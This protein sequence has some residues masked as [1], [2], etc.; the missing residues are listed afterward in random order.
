MVVD[1]RDRKK[2]AERQIHWFLRQGQNISVAEGIK[3]RYR[4]KLDLGDERV[5]W[6]TQIVMSSLPANQLPKSMKR[7]GAKPVCIVESVL[8]N[9]DM[10]LKNRH[11]Y[12]FAP[13][14]QRADFDVK[15][16]VGAADLKFQL[17]GKDGR[18]SKDHEE[19]EVQWNSPS[20]TGQTQPDLADG[21]AMYQA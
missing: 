6:K 1:P 14:Y 3:H 19:I 4:L 12:N 2:W 21:T 13:Q 10:K 8:G 9:T 20:A 15:V 18:M 16:I 5:P 17:W 7:E 11:W